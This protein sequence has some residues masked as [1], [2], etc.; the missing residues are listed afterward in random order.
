[1]AACSKRTCTTSGICRLRTQESSAPGHLQLPADPSKKDPDPA[2]FDYSTI[3]DVILHLRYTARE[4]GGLLRQA[5][6]EN[7]K[8]ATGLA[9]AGGVRLFSIRH[10][11]PSE[12]ARFKNASADDHDQFPLTLA[13]QKNHY[14]FWS[15]GYLNKVTRLDVVSNG[16]GR[17]KASLTV[18]DHTSP[19]PMPIDQSMGGLLHGNAAENLPATPVT[20]LN[21]AFDSQDLNDLWIAMTW[22]R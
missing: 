20:E 16:T 21:M 11:F 14:P 2:Q 15:Q 22:S 17:V 1:M 7:L 19:I 13:L 3:S 9:S 5:A 10:E 6:M 18:G 4:G 12:W 8:S